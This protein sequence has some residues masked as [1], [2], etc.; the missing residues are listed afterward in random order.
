MTYKEE[1][2][3]LNTGIETIYGTVNWVQML[4]NDKRFLKIAILGHSGGS[5]I[6]I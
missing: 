2:I 6:G 4:H 3:Q 5:L 1:N